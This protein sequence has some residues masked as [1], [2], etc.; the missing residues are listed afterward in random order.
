M[1]THSVKAPG[2][3]VVNIEPYEIQNLRTSLHQMQFLFH[4][5]LLYNGEKRYSGPCDV[6][7]MQFK[8][9][10]LWNF[11]L[12]QYTFWF[13]CNDTC[14]YFLSPSTFV[15]LFSP[16]FSHILPMTVL[17]KVA[18]TNERPSLT[19][20]DLQWAA[21]CWDMGLDM[22]MK[23]W[24]VSIYIWIPKC[25]KLICS[26]YLYIFRRVLFLH[27][28]IRRIHFHSNVVWKCTILRI[29]KLTPQ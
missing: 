17:T 7:D 13:L 3:L 24:N 5:H 19:I 4:T 22:E 20:C 18:Y 11:T 28:S 14:E 8:D 10:L 15:I 2:P 29:G 23:M 25:S 27:L 6:N 26:V 12:S 21:Q 16:N 1:T 9:L